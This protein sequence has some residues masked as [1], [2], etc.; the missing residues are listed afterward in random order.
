MVSC[1][2]FIALIIDP[3]RVWI[4]WMRVRVRSHRLNETDW[5]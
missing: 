2:L 5:I 4:V 3:M 1:V